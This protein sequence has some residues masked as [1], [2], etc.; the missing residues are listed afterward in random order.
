MK[1]E[2]QPSPW[3]AWSFEVMKKLKFQQE[4]I[5][6]LECTV[7]DLCKQLKQLESKPAYTIENIQYHFD[8]LKVEKLEGTLNIGMSL[9]DADSFGSQ[10]GNGSNGSTNGNSG[11]GGAGGAGNIDQFSVGQ[12]SG[13]V[14]PAA[15]PA[16]TPPPQPYNDIYRRLTR[17][18][19][20]EA[21]QTLLKCEEELELPLDPYHRRIIL[22]DVRKQ[23]PTRIQF[24]WQMQTKDG[25]DT[26]SLYPDLIADR[27]FDKTKRDA[28]A[29]I[30]TYMRSLKAGNPMNG[31][32]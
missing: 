21:H 24:Y 23:M 20:T 4:R 14:F 5:E 12:G 22:E 26:A 3:Q 10:A 9:P 27:V 32:D 6:R 8:Q 29:A 1:D 15:S 30:D 19:D 7:D 13:N 2:S 11:N 31:G 17:Y 18:L 28:E 16:I 25:T